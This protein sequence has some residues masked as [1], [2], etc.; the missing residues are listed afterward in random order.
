MIE[1]ADTTVGSDRRVK[2]PLYAAAGISEVW[3]VDLPARRLQCFRQPS[4]TGYGEVVTFEVGD[5]VAPL[6][7]PDV[8]L[9]VAELVGAIM[10]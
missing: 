6:A 3:L 5:I 7:F 1:V 9:V 4:P 10:G 2:V 8:S